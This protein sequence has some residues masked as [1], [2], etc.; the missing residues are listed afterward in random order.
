[1]AL[2]SAYAYSLDFALS[3]QLFMTTSAVT[4]EATISRMISS[5]SHLS[6]GSLTRV[7]NMIALDS[8]PPALI[9]A[10]IESISTFQSK[11]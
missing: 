3:Q 6:A 2:T 7:L 8:S 11:V 5:A 10:M 1:M 9:C 4:P